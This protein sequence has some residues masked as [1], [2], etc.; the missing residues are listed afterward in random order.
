M[1][2]NIANNIDSF[3]IR[4]IDFNN[5]I[6]NKIIKGDNSFFTGIVFK[7]NE[8]TLNNLCLYFKI[9]SPISKKYTN[10]DKPVNKNVEKC[11]ENKYKC[12]LKDVCDITILKKLEIIERRILDKYNSLNN[13]NYEKTYTFNAN[14]LNSRYFKYYVNNIDF[15]EQNTKA[16]IFKNMCINNDNLPP[17]LFCKMFA[18][19]ISGVWQNNN[20]IGV[21]YKICLL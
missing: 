10:L 12:I 9:K 19:K 5:T 20:K 21:S 8:I 13:T 7:N 4:N 11:T 15:L 2:L 3:N 1:L 16:S 18:I 6:K 14:D 17:G